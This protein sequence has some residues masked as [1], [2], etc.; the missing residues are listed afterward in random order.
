MIIKRYTAE[1]VAT[2]LIA[3]K[4]LIDVNLESSFE[5]DVSSAEEG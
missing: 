4:D 3:S 2:I 5:S 1:K